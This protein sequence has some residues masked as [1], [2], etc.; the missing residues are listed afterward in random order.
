MFE[1]IGVKVPNAVITNIQIHSSKLNHS[2]EKLRLSRLPI[3][4]SARMDFHLE[5]LDA[6]VSHEEQLKADTDHPIVLVNI[7]HC[8]PSLVEDLI[9]EW[10]QVLQRFKSTDGFIS[11][12]FH[13]GI[14]GSG[15]VLNYAVFESTAHYRAAFQKPEFQSMI[16][17]YPKGTV[18]TPH[19]FKK[20]AVPNICVE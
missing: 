19:L 4:I 8:D 6:H 18:A 5:Q 11:A 15:T 17:K 10:T 16:M 14:A 13:R 20:V 12:Q 7:F 9:S 3:S 2:L 1:T